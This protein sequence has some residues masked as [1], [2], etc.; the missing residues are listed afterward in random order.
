MRLALE[1]PGAAEL[2]T[3]DTA[4]LRLRPLR[5]SDAA[6]IL[7]VFGDAAVV[8]YWNRPRFESRGDATAYLDRLQGLFER[9]EA[10]TWAIAHRASPST[11]DAL[12][13][14][15]V[16]FKLDAA[17]GRAEIGYALARRLWGQGLA[18][19]TLHALIGLAFDGFGLRRLE[20][21][22]DPRNAASCALLASLGFTLEGRM[23]ERW[24]V[25][26]EPS[27][28]ACYGLLAREWQARQPPASDD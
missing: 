12:V 21:D 22:T 23:R 11:P 13:G 10:Y 26:G 18:H 3:L 28:S 7:A 6:G 16:L 1:L 9:R 27:D 4:R 8:R 5:A 17:N 24:R 25:A 14:T 19:E 20:A 15:C 2:P